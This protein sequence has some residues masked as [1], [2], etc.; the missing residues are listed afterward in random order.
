[1]VTLFRGKQDHGT[2]P[3]VD[4]LFFA[5][6]TRDQVQFWPDR[7]QFLLGDGVLQS[8]HFRSEADWHKSVCPLPNHSPPRRPN[9]RGIAQPA[10]IR[11][12]GERSICFA[13]PFSNLP[14][15]DSVT[16]AGRL[17][18]FFAIDDL[19]VSPSVRYESGFL[20]HARGHGHAG[21]ARAQH[22]G[23]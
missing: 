13:A 11:T 21:A 12:N 8:A 1:M 6:R 9:R 19:N 2:R 23:D 17:F 20:K 4:R 16:L 15:H 7:D 5:V 3:G 10:R 22:L 14:L 18:Q